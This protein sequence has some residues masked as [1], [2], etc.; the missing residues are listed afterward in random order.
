MAYIN[1]RTHWIAH[2]TLA[3]ALF[4]SVMGWRQAAM[5]RDLEHAR[6]AEAGARASGA[7]LVVKERRKAVTARTADRAATRLSEANQG[8]PTWADLPVPQ[9]VQDAL[10]P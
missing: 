5:S 7:A 9:E 8:H 1:P 2:L 4:G 3:L 10:A 6:A